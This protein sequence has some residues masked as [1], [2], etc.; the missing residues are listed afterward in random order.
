M[1][2]SLKKRIDDLRKVESNTQLINL[3]DEIIDLLD[4]TRTGYDYLRGLVD[5]S[6]T[7]ADVVEKLSVEPGDVLIAKLGDPKTGWIPGPDDE[8]RFLG[9]FKQAVAD[10]GFPDVTCLVYHY[11]VQF[12]KLCGRAKRQLIKDGIL[13]TPIH[14]KDGSWYFWDETYTKEHGPFVSRHDCASA[15]REYAR[16]L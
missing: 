10:G 6:P 2:E 11:G 15:L 4:E 8:D 12:E 7:F 13:E 3:L 9:L 14:E 16:G 1:T 5:K